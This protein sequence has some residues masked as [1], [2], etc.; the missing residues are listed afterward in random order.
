MRSLSCD[1]LVIGGGPAGLAA[2]CAAR[3]AGARQ[4]LII[5]RN[6]EL[7]GILP[8][9]IHNGFGLSYFG[10][11]LTGPEYAERW[12]R[13]AEQT[14]IQA[15]LET[16][17]LEIGPDLRAVA[18]SGQLGLVALQPKALILAMGCRERPRGALAIP[19]T[20]PAGIY[21]A[22]TAQRLVNIE[23]YMPGRRFVILGSGDIGM[24]MARRLTL[25]GAHV[26]GMIEILPYVSGLRRNLVQCVR[27]FYIPL[28]L[29]TT[30]TEV[31][32]LGR[33]EAVVTSQVDDRW[34]PIPGT[35]QEVACDALLLSV[36][37][38][39][40]NELSRMAGVALD[41]R[42]GGPYV[43]DRLATSAPG[44]YAAGNVLHVYD[45][46]DEVTRS[47]LLAGRQAADY[48][49]HGSRPGDDRRIAVTAGHN[50]RHVIPQHVRCRAWTDGE[51]KL[52]FRVR[53]PVEEALRAEVVVDDEVVLSQRFRYARPSEMLVIEIDPRELSARQRGHLAEAPEWVVRM[54][55]PAP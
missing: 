27:D 9:C 21:T 51:V 31:M 4:V 52:E 41:A 42:T 32:G 8:Q 55:A 28:H 16:M 23:G 13:Q 11:D 47:A 26:A 37:L 50:V 5:E 2:A 6:R 12:I 44:I 38:I 49:R 36:G 40:E 22:G 30:V 33:V 20:R 17:V 18:V 1:V 48:A 45:L 10:A 46:V 19:G 24:I 53:E 54:T 15:L 35:Q 14:G 7:G 29:C 3:E 43:D 25:E 34:R 39:P